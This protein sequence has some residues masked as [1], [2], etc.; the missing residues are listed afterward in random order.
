M[1]E[2]ITLSKAAA[3]LQVSRR[4][5]QTLVQK[6]MLT[7]ENGMVSVAEITHLYPRFS[8]EDSPALERSKIIKASSFGRRVSQTVA[9][10]QDELEVRLERRDRDLAIARADAKYYR[11]LSECMMAALEKMRLQAT[12]DQ[13]S[14]IEKLMQVVCHRQQDRFN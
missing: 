6:G 11:E 8:L 9:P 10:E 13:L 12:A 7:A 2:M 3:I 4:E 1:A 5:L 14:M